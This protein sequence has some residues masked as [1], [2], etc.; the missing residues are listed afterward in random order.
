MAFAFKKNPERPTLIAGPCMAESLELLETVVAPLHA[1]SKELKFDLIF[2]ASFDKA[3]RTSIGSYRGPGLPQ[4]LKWFDA[5]KSKYPGLPVL[6]DIHETI[7]VA[8]AAEVIDVLQIPAFLCRQTDL[9][10]AAAQTG[11]AV[12]VKKGQFLAPENAQHIISKMVA[13]S[14]EKGFEPNYALTERGVTFGYGN[15]IVDMRGLKIMSDMGAPT[16]FDIT[17]SLQLP[18]AG[19]SSGEVSGGLRNF[20]P[21]LARSATATGYL[22]GYFLEVHADPNNAKS[23]AA[24]QLSI[25]Q[26]TVLLRQIIPLWYHLKGSTQNDKVFV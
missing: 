17:H 11:R 24:T 7:Q 10:V 12:N 15:L 26:A 13:A 3:N 1:L 9:L 4:T 22:D 5:I 23:D 18:A 16:I 25:E 19:G 21:V 6:T 20:A 8:E 2:K 14:K